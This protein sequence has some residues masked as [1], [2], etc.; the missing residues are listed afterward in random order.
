MREL[1]LHMDKLTR[2]TIMELITDTFKPEPP[3]GFGWRSGE[4]EGFDNWNYAVESIR[5]R[6]VALYPKELG[7]D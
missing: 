1:K 3:K 4:R 5:K 2:A 6:F 7:Q